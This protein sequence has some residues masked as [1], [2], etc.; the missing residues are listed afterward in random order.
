MLRNKELKRDDFRGSLNQEPRQ[1]KRLPYLHPARR[2]ARSR[3]Q[4]SFSRRRP[5]PG[6]PPCY[7]RREW[8]GSADWEKSVGQCCP[9][10][11]TVMV[12]KFSSSCFCFLSCWLLRTGATWISSVPDR[13]DVYMAR[14]FNSTI[15]KTIIGLSNQ[16]VFSVADCWE[17]EWRELSSVADRTDVYM[18]RN[19]P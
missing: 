10:T 1:P 3:H 4:A 5:T 11:S 7:W 17:L 13:A 6:N 2:D 16:A 18:V 12:I 9:S 8:W 14:N 15:R 19:E